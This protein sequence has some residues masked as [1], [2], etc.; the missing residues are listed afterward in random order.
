MLLKYYCVTSIVKF[1]SSS[2]SR[3]HFDGCKNAILH[4]GVA[5]CAPYTGR[6]I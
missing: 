5:T 2:K 6:R 3:G 1:L 4:A